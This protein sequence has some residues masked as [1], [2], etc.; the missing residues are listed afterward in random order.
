MFWIPHLSRWFATKALLKGLANSGFQIGK[1][2]L[3]SCRSAPLGRDMA[4]ER[5]GRQGALG[6]GR[7]RKHWQWLGPVR[8]GKGKITGYRGREGL[9]DW[10]EGTGDC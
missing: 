4:Q 6:S 7:G 2:R 9:H 3:P 5:S 1:L 10:V 8:E